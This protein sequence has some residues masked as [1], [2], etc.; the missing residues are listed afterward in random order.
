MH[1][2]AHCLSP[3]NLCHRIISEHI[4]LASPLYPLSLAVCV[5]VCVRFIYLCADSLKAEEE[6]M[7]LIRP[8]KISNYKWSLQQL[9]TSLNIILILAILTQCSSP[10][11]AIKR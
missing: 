9:Q 7:H 6:V 8:K 2:H 11:E 1:S 3:L 5:Y 10:E 4:C